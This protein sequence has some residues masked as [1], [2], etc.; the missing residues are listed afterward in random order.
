MVAAVADWS[1]HLL[2]RHLVRR[3]MLQHAALS[4]VE[5]TVGA[6]QAVGSVTHFKTSPIIRNAHMRKRN[7]GYPFQPF[8][9]CTYVAQARGKY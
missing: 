4:V 9:G 8:F 1:L 3:H 5:A 2:R 6:L 7:N